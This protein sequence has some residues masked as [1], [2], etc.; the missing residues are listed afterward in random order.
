MSR[1]ERNQAIYEDNRKTSRGTGAALAGR[2]FIC[3]GIVIMVFVAAACLTIMIPKAA[4]FESYVVVSGSMEP[5]IPVGSIVYSEKAD[6]QLL[7]AGDVIVFID[8]SRGT[9]PITHRI[10]SNNPYTETIITKGDANEGED[11]N[12]VHYGNVIGKVVRYVPHIGFTAAMFTSVIGKTVAVLLLLEAW[13][14]T[15]VG[16]RLTARRKKQVND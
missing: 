11:V 14:L 9:I 10:M 3:V 12:P 5:N 4:G 16:R 13:L 8:E 2:F 1:V 7:R 6:P 15:E